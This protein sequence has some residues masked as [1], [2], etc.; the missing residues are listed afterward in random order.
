MKK[1]LT[2]YTEP[3]FVAAN[4]IMGLGVA[5]LAAAD[6]GMSMTGA[7]A[8]LLSLRF[9]F[10]SFGTCEL[11]I[12]LI[13]ILLTFAVIG[14]IKLR[15]F[16]SLLSGS[17]YALFL[18]LWR[19]VIPALN[20]AV[21]PSGAFSLPVRIFLFVAGVLLVMFS[22][23]VFFR[24][25]IYPQSYDLFVRELCRKYGIPKSKAKT[26]FDCSFLLLGIVLSLLFFSR[27]QAIGVG[28]V[29]LSLCG[30]S[31][32]GICDRRLT[33]TTRFRPLFPKAV[34]LFE[35]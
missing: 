18:D 14:R 19:A 22:V 17:V 5:M 7:P 21:T 12:Q 31:L 26:G 15:L 29:A 23:A 24:C 32:L 9:P 27:I 8:Y 34:A 35:E 25:Y 28:T 33:E 13:L 1:T 6:L 16:L 11:L 3:A 4:V 2:V 10:L 30:G 20:P